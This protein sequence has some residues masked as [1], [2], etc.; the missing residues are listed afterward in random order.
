MLRILNKPNRLG[1]ALYTRLSALDCAQ[2]GRLSLAEGEG[3]SE[4]DQR[5]LAGAVSNPSPQSSPLIRG[6]AEHTRGA[7]NSEQNSLGLP[8]PLPSNSCRLAHELRIPDD[9]RRIL[10]S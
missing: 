4:V 9:F 1:N 2:A 5:P 8:L 7:A 10:R 3:E 6:E